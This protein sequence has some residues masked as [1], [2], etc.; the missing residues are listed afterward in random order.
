MFVS[1]Q[2]L[3]NRV[4]QRESSN[5]FKLNGSL[6]E[7]GKLYETVRQQAIA[8]DQS[9]SGHVDALRTRAL[10]RLQELEKKMLRAEKRKYEALQ[11]QILRIRE[12]YFRGWLTGKSG[13]YALFLR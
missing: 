11:R 2:E 13:Q 5:S 9:L 4:V 6:T 7:I 1:S 12:N 10:Y 3:M 8:V